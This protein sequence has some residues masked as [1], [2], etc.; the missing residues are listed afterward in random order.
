[1][2]SPADLGDGYTYKTLCFFFPAPDFETFPITG[3]I[4]TQAAAPRIGP[5]DPASQSHADT[6]GKKLGPVKV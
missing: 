1:M 3:E 5:T 2:G 6:G 4:V